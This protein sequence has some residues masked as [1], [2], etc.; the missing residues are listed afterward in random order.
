M[1]VKNDAGDSVGHRQFPEEVYT[2]GSVSSP[3]KFT[4]EVSNGHSGASRSP[5]TEAKKLGKRTTRAPHSRTTGR[6]ANTGIKTTEIDGQ[7]QNRTPETTRG[8][9][10]TAISTNAPCRTRRRA[11]LRPH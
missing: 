2:H 9:R 10:N 11:L 7:G 1:G 4:E 8:S 6:P 3:E 5:G